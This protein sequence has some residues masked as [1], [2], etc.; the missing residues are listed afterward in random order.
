MSLKE[1]RNI[2]WRVV[3]LYLVGA[4]VAGA[5]KYHYSTAGSDDL[6]WILSPTA[7]LVHRMTGLGFVREARA[8]FINHEHRILIAPACAGVNFLIISFCTVFFSLVHRLASLSRKWL[9]LAVALA[10]SYVATIAVNA[11]R[12]ALSIFLIEHD[13]RYGWLTAE[14]IHRLEGIA[15]YFLFLSFFFL[16]MKRA[17]TLAREGNGAGSCLRPFPAAVAPLCWYLV[18]T[19]AVPLLNGS[20]QAGNPGFIEHFWTVLPVCVLLSLLLAGVQLCSKRLFLKMGGTFAKG[21]R[22]R[23]WDKEC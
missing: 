5:L 21:L 19:L 2:S 23:S 6:S 13:V 15:V 12:I 8:G 20:A 18:V 11:L 3:A 16:V 17:A 10:S 1:L 14:R 7:F 4:I 22:E 9:W